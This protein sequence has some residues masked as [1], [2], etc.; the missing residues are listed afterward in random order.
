MDR[1]AGTALRWS[2]ALVLSAV[3]FVG[4][5]VGHLSAGGLLPGH[6]GL[7]VVFVLL[8]ALS[9]RHLGRPAS[10][11]RVV[12]LTAAGQTLVHLALTAMAGHRG[13]PVH[14]AAP[15]AAP[16]P[17]PTGPWDRT[18]LLYRSAP[19]PSGTGLTVPEPVQHLVADL[20]GPHAAMAVAHLGAAA[21][22][23]LWL[24]VL[25]RSVWLVVAFL[26]CSLA[27]ALA[28]LVALV[29]G[30]PALPRPAAPSS[31]Y[32]PVRCPSRVTLLG[33]RVSRR[34]PPLLLATV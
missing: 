13:D 25:E 30:R 29:V 9:A 1:R 14:V 10:T 20:S 12:V 18:E 21:L 32:L 22:V 24:A 11:L 8:T 28:V 16:L 4:G 5:T 3:A 34:G 2:R 7:L 23:G 26:G 19:H 31:S 33:T 17:A 27:G 15:P 6:R